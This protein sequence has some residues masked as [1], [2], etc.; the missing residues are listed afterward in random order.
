ME[1]SKKAL[2]NVITGVGNKIILMILAF[3]TRTLFIK[4][5]GAEYTGVSSLY[6]NILS[7][8]SLAELGLGN[9]L[10]FYLYSAIKDKD[11][12]KI[13]CLVS[14]F[15]RIYQV[16]IVV[17]LSIG[18]ALIPFLGYIINSDLNYKEVVLYYCMYLINSVA[19]Y[20]VVYRTMVIAA[21]QNGYITNIVST[22]S[23]ISMYI[24]QITYL[25]I[26]KNFIGYLI[27]QVLC[28]ILNNLVLNHIAL[29]KYPFLKKHQTR[30]NN[31]IDKK[32]LFKN[33]KAT[34]LFKISDTILDQTDSIIISIMF[35]TSFVG[36]Y[37]N[38]FL[39][40]TFIVAIAGIIANGLV[41]SFGNLVAEGNTEHSYKMLRLAMLAFAVFGTVCTSCYASI[42]QEFIPVWIGPEYVKDYSWVIA[43]LCVFYLRMVTNTMWMYRSAMGLF[44]EVQYINMIAALLNIVL[45]IIFGMWIGLPGVIVATAISRLFTSFWYEGKV[46]FKKLDK[47]VIIYYAQ[48]LKDFLI[49]VVSVVIC[50]S[51]SDLIN[52]H[53]WLGIIIKFCSSFFIS[54]MIE[55]AVYYR[56]EEY[57]MMKSKILGVFR[58]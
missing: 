42:V 33:I 37:Y 21:D 15:K 17:V 1:R 16:I 12:N 44:K 58:R 36:Y 50:V 2:R 19:S 54:L 7:V 13:C 20:F 29:R 55:I 6:T 28:T 31:I 52:V 5:L 30:E 3:T 38:Y 23:T 41:A 45:S 4:L 11:E 46:L 32:E 53:G 40:I 51:M 56:T 22:V 27:I 9:V 34:F 49:C 24:L 39:L 47:S 57:K 26:Y 14:E 48:Q 25:K 43:I 18:L 35:G 8:L 10:M